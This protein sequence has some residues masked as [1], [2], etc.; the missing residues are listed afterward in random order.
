MEYIFKNLRRL[1]LSNPNVQ[2]CFYRIGDWME[3]EGNTF[4]DKM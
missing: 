4:R 2:D 1:D 3:T